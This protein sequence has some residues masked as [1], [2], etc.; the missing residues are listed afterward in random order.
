MRIRRAGP[1]TL[2]LTLDG[3]N[4]TLPRATPLR[5]FRYKLRI[6][7]EAAPHSSTNRRPTPHSGDRAFLMLRACACVRRWRYHR[8]SAWNESGAYIIRVSDREKLERALVR[9]STIPKAGDLI[10][11]V[12]SVDLSD[13]EA[14]GRFLKKRV[15]A[16]DVFSLGV[17]RIVAP[18]PLAED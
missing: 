1:L 11:T 13:S 7:H 17:N 6:L 9:G 16:G 2:T 3:A 5:H 10:V 12:N 15:V 8:Q 4:P 18:R 14:L